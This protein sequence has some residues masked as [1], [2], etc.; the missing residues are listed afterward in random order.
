MHSTS[1][2]F[3]VM[4]E[5]RGCREDIPRI[6]LSGF[7]NIFAIDGNSTDGT[8]EY[9]ADCGITVYRQRIPSLNAAYW[10]AVETADSGNLIVFFPKGTIDPDIIQTLRC[11]L[12]ECEVVVA[13]RFGE[14]AVN[15]EDQR[16]FRPRK[17]GVQALSIFTSLIWRHEGPRMKDVLHGVK[18]FSINAFQRMNISKR[19][20]TI[21]LEMNVRAYR[22]N[23]SRCEVPVFE[24]PRIS[25]KTHFPIWPTGRKLAAFLIRELLSPQRL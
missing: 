14:R 17:W 4:N 12:E 5:L 10:Q 25:G 9:L 2:C 15:E 13:S 24:K 22:L 20:V 8:A 11:R 23:L 3:I 18:G 16:L 6:D 19:G 21:D 7:D 1:L